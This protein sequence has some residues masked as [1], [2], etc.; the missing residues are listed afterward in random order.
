MT[1]RLT[2]PPRK[3]HG[4]DQPSQLM[5]DLRASVR[6]VEAEASKARPRVPEMIE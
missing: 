1:T 2:K 3:K 4:G 6:Q 5:V